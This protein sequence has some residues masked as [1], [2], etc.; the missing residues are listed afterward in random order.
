MNAVVSVT[1]T[2]SVPHGPVSIR[3][4]SRPV[5]ASQMRT[6][7]VSVGGGTGSSESVFQKRLEITR[8]PSGV[9]NSWA[10]PA[11]SMS[12]WTAHTSSSV[13]MSMT[14]MS[15]TGQPYV[16]ETTIS[17]PSGLRSANSPSAGRSA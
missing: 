12:W 9:K 15:L 3:L 17:R 14:A 2:T 7:R 16:L 13:A 10:K 6:P 11:P 8:V 1:A 5:F 4:I